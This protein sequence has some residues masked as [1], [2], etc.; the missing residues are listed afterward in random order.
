[1]V[2]LQNGGNVVTI[3]MGP[4]MQVTYNCRNV[5]M[6]ALVQSLRTMIS[7]S[8]NTTPAGRGQRLERRLGLRPHLFD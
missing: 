6:E 5:T 4:N 1:M 2:M 3:A 8:L 7:T